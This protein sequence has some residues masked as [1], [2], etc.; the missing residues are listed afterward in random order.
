M[1]NSLRINIPETKAYLLIIGILSATLI[2]FNI[3][4]IENEKAEIIV[5]LQIIII[6]ML[7]L[8]TNVTRGK[9]RI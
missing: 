7:S 3:Y 9:R 2:Y 1:K 5:Y 8:P 4:I 6:K